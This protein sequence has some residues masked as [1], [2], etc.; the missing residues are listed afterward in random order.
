M[1]RYTILLLTSFMLIVS[2]TAGSAL[3]AGADKN[4]IDVS[5]QQLTVYTTLPAEHVAILSEA[6]ESSHNVK[7]NFIPL[8][9]Q[10]LVQ[11]VKND[12]VSDP[13]VITTSDIVIAD[14]NVLNEISNSN[15]FTPYISEINDAV[16]PSFKQEFGT[17]IGVWYDPIIFCINQDFLL[18]LKSPV[19]ESWS[20]L[21]NYPNIRIGIT[22]FLAADASSN[23]MFQMIAQF[24]DE[25]TFDILNQL[26]PKVV[27]Y[28]KYLSNPVRQAGMGEVDI[29]IAVESESLRYI[30]NGYPLKIIYPVDG[31]AYMLTGVGISTV[32]KSKLKAAEIFS[33]WLLSDEAQRVL[34]AN[35]FYFIS[36]NPQTLAHKKFAGKN[37]RLFDNPHIFSPQQKQ[38]YL[39]RWLTQIRFGGIK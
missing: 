28:A 36:A 25:S 37:L 1:R 12:S 22:D 39:D 21:A 16:R 11:R 4:K 8:A 7:L 26:H 30:Q 13:S 15:L 29:S 14:K 17:W 38:S 19:P 2:A 34:Q 5:I 18:N 20:E 33:D 31:T 23:L 27:Q 10:E 24:G 6:Y 3:L 9:P 35:G 32:D